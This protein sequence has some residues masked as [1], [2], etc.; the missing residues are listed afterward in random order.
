V[1]DLKT[2]VAVS[3]ALVMVGIV[4]G[5]APAWRAAQVPPAEALRGQ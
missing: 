5:V 4:A 2:V 3:S 1:V